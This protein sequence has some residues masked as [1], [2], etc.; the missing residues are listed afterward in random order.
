MI[1]PKKIEEWT[2]LADKYRAAAAEYA[3]L[4]EQRRRTG[5]A[6]TGYAGDAEVE[7]DDRLRCVAKDAIPA[8]LAE[9]EEMQRSLRAM[10]ENLAG[11]LA[12]E[13]KLGR[14]VRDL[15]RE[16]ETV[17]QE[18]VRLREQAA[19]AEADRRAFCQA[20]YPDGGDDFDAA[21]LGRT[22]A[23]EVCRVLLARQREEVLAVLREVEWLPVTVGGG[24][25]D[26]ERTEL[27]CPRCRRRPPGGAKIRV[28]TEWHDDPS[29]CGHASDCRLAALLGRTP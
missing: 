9:R 3:R 14:E 25:G 20:A 12:R 7:A 11:A 17:H 6:V 28:G 18:L 2:R 21:M 15:L 1:D 23:S 29:E 4:E 8:L 5:F 24:H 27:R 16:R 22:P 19:R 13:D 26:P 10:D